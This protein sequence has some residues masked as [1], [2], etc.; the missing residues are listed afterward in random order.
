MMATAGHFDSRDKCGSRTHS[1]NAHFVDR[2]G[3]FGGSGVK[4]R[5][6]GKEFGGS[7]GQE[8]SATANGVPYCR[9][10]SQKGF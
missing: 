4:I 6:L 3:D 2:D 8:S 9:N 10:V 1:G 7:D 5:F